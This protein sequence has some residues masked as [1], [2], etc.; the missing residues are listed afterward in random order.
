EY[1]R[2][3]N[4]S[5]SFVNNQLTEISSNEF[6]IGLGY[7]IK[8][9]RFNISGAMA[10]GKKTKTNS[11]LNL[12]CDFSIRRNKTVLRRIDQDINQISVGQQVLSLNFSADYNLSA[13]FN[14]RFYFDKTINKPYVSNQYRTSNTKG[15]FA[16]RFNLAQ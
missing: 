8:G 16:L 4:L 1:K 12:K 7:R 11:D 3:R 9:I 6:V 5:M 13:R 14:I 10:G 2:S 15:G